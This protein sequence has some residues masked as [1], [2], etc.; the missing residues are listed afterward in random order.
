PAS[1]SR[2]CER[3]GSASVA[4]GPALAVPRRVE[5]PSTHPGRVWGQQDRLG[6]QARDTEAFADPQA[7]QEPAE[8]VGWPSVT[9]SSAEADLRDWILRGEGDALEPVLAQHIIRPA[10]VRAA[11]APGEGSRLCTAE[12]ERAIPTITAQLP[13]PPRRVRRPCTQAVAT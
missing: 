12:A 13:I 1:A 4:C 7:E 5:L 6:A 9:S 10:A 11:F 8:M 2:R 3:S